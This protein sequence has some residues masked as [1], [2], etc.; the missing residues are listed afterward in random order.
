MAI[1]RIGREDD[2]PAGRIERR[3]LLGR[4]I[5]IYR[6]T[7]GSLAATEA[8]CRHQNADLTVGEREGDIVTCPR[9]GWRYD[10]ATG[11]CLTEAWARLRTFRVWTED[12]E[13][14]LDTTPI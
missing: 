2:F 12:E 11:E 5:G 4:H 13:V 14:Y 10:L 9:H 3:S 8:T 6:R 7:D 1:L